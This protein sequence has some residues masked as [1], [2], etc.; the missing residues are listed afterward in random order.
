MANTIRSSIESWKAYAKK[1]KTKIIVLFV[2]LMW[3]CSSFSGDA[4][5]FVVFEGVVWITI[6]VLKGGYRFTVQSLSCI[7]MIAIPF[8]LIE[9]KSE[10]NNAIH[11]DPNSMFPV[12]FE[13][14]H[15]E[16][17][18][19]IRLQHIL[20]FYPATPTSLSLCQT[21]IAVHCTPFSITLREGES[22][23]CWFEE[24]K[25]GIIGRLSSR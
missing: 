5:P 25:R 23:S 19:L 1:A 12:P 20:S 6:H 16:L 3:F 18:Q 22:F 24:S 4:L 13:V 15:V 7:E 14:W 17:L 11:S 10:V 21:K 2:I 9:M 8:S